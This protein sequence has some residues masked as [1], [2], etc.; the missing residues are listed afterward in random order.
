MMFEFTSQKQERKGRWEPSFVSN[1]KLNFRVLI[2][3]YSRRLIKNF[4][5]GGWA[6]LS[7]SKLERQR[8]SGPQKRTKSEFIYC[9]QGYRPCSSKLDLPLSDE[10]FWRSQILST[11]NLFDKGCTQVKLSTWRGFQLSIRPARRW[12]PK[13]PSNTNTD[14]I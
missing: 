2:Q 6:L 5:W 11:S 10:V 12:C 8:T 7:E 4:C 9:A 13:T 14:H 3:P 1:L